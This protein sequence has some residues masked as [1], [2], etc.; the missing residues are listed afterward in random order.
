MTPAQIL[1]H[2]LET[3]SCLPATLIETLHSI[4]AVDKAQIDPLLLGIRFQEWLYPEKRHQLG[5]HYTGKADIELIIKPV[6]MQPLLDEWDRLKSEAMSL[7][8]QGDSAPAH[9][10]LQTFA[11]NIAA[12][13]VLDPAC[14]SGNFLYIALQHLLDLQ[15]EVIVFAERYNLPAIPLTVG[16]QQ[17]HG[18]EINVYAHELA[19]IT[20]WIGYIQWRFENGL[21]KLSQPILQPLNTIKLMDAI[22]GYNEQGQPYEPEWVAAEVIIGNPPF[23][24]NKRLRREF[25]DKYIDDLYKLYRHRLPSEIDLVC[26]WFDKSQQMLSQGQANRVG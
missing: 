15:K 21:E 26:Y 8:R 1:R 22:L 17:L 12:L 25:G 19:Q 20:V 14:G 3:Q 18:M 23:L 5:V 4:C 10:I 7:I 16:P 9:T 6:L 2:Y 13:Q 24:G 11:T